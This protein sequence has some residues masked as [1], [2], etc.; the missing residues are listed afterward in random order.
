VLIVFLLFFSLP[1]IALGFPIYYITQDNMKEEL[2]KNNEN[3]LVQIKDNLEFMIDDT[4]ALNVA[5]STNPELIMMLKHVLN[6]GMSDSKFLRN[7]SI[8][9]SFL[10]SLVASRPYIY[11]I[12]IYSEN[13]SNNFISSTDG[14]GTIDGYFDTSWFESYL[15]HQ[16]D[17]LAFWIDA[18]SIKRYSFESETDVITIYKKFFSENGIIALNIT[19]EFLVKKI[20]ELN[21]LQDQMITVLDESNNIILK[22]RNDHD[23]T[24]SVLKHIQ[25]GSNQIVDIGE[26]EYYINQI[27]SDKY[28]WKYFRHPSINLV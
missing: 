1:V 25:G 12:Y 2:N 23:L 13:D 4:D 22:S 18:R 3:I 16:D 14:L 27:N 6:N 5:Y 10:V 19:K 20:N 17:K 24:G 8:I 15:D 11:S 9:K 21:L 28:K 7:K 26:T